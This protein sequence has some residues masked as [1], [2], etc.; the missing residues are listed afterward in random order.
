MITETHVIKQGVTRAQAALIVASHRKPTIDVGDL[1]CPACLRVFDEAQA[2]SQG[3][4]FR[5][6]VWGDYLRCP[7]CNFPTWA[8]HRKE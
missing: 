1:W 5:K 6:T 4:L 7:D 2:R 8:P 3:R